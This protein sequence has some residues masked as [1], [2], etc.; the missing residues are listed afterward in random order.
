MVILFCLAG[1]FFCL[2]L[3][4][5]NLNRSFSRQN[6]MPVGT[7]SWKQKVAQRRFQDRVL[8]TRLQQNAPVYYGDYIR[9]AELS[10]AAITFSGGTSIRLEENSLIQILSENNIP[11][12][13]FTQGSL[14]IDS[15]SSTGNGEIMV[16]DAAGNLISVTPGTVL[17]THIDD[18]GNMSLQVSEGSASIVIDGENQNIDAGGALTLDACGSVLAQAQTVVRSPKPAARLIQPVNSPMPV[19]FIW[20]EI[21]YAPGD[22]TRIELAA[23]R[24]FKQI[25]QTLETSSVNGQTRA[26]IE[27]APGVYFW[28]AYPVGEAASS[29]GVSAAVGSANVS[30]HQLTV[31]YVPPPRPL[32][33]AEGSDYRYWSQ[34]PTV[35]FQWT[36]SPEVSFYTLEAADNPG[37]VSPALQTRVQGASL[38][39]SGL[40]KG[41][42][43]WRVLPVLGSGYEGARS[44]APSDPVSFTITQNGSLAAPTLLSPPAESF[45]TISG[46]AATAKAASDIYF[47]W[48]SE[49]EAGSYTLLVSPLPGLQN[50]VF[51]RQATTNYYN[52][53][54]KENLLKE[55]LYYWGVY[56]TSVDGI[57]SPLSASRS[58]SA[59]TG[60]FVLRS[61]FPPENY[62]VQGSGLPEFTWTTNLVS[63]L[64]FQISDTR[65]FS[66][67][68][69]DEIAEGGSW[70]ATAASRRPSLDPGR[71]YWRVAAGD[72]NVQTPARSFQ[73]VPVPPP[74]PPPPVAP[75]P[76]A[77]VPAAQAP[78]ATVSA[79]QAP[80]ATVP[81]AQA[82]SATV[83]ATQAPSATV[84]VA[85]APAATVPAV[86]GQDVSSQATSV[87]AASAPVTPLR[88][89]RL[90]LPGNGYRLGPEQLRESEFIT[91]TWEPVPGANA[92]NAALYREG[93]RD[94]GRQLI[95]RWDTSI[96]TFR[97]LEVS[98]LGNGRFVWQVEALR[99]AAD[100]AIEQRG[101]VSE[102][103]F[104][105]DIPALPRDTANDP[106]KLY[107]N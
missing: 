58:F 64:H 4:W 76:A 47:S 37:F 3:F 8:W 52:Y 73:V 36:A 2:W 50:P 92:Y 14:S 55:G 84:P 56:Q 74:P 103:R 67:L 33:P 25:L 20:N 90:L 59:T 30:F 41:R 95:Q 89:A 104:T 61:T 49:A 88:A 34:L 22:T 71:W 87:P 94:G 9:T 93:E 11:R 13:A 98:L 68:V 53:S 7:L 45:I 5:Q 86:P 62:T 107:G 78:A 26:R 82:P 75:S 51:T 97:T 1:A 81:A 27:L 72:G 23:D 100:D 40:G 29:S 79:A 80:A 24:N 70:T 12:L 42:W 60:E 17:D 31:S 28:R 91:F 15:L 43:Y 38:N 46:T 63:P 44:L 65:D 10:E 6:V 102:N 85:Q 16:L 48:K 99:L 66:R 21:D 106:G 105:A 83:P 96:R 39:Y 19:E 32:I 77:S 35:E 54:V 18:E 69:I 101:P 57:N